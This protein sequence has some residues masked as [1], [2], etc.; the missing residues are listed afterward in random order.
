MSKSIAPTAGQKQRCGR[1]A[2]SMAMRPKQ[3]GISM[4]ATDTQSVRL[5]FGPSEIQ[6]ADGDA[7]KRRFTT[8]EDGSA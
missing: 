2:P 5:C 7:G 1:Q 6:A 8:Q 4:S 3:T